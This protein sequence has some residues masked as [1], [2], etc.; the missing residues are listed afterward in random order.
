M[1]VYGYVAMTDE[2]IGPP[3][4]SPW[5]YFHSLVIFC[6]GIGAG[7]VQGQAGGTDSYKKNKIIIYMV[8]EP[9]QWRKLELEIFALGY[10]LFA[11]YLHFL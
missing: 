7:L 6:K 1:N 5:L 2:R 11:N 9:R 8:L 10:F 3:C 4:P